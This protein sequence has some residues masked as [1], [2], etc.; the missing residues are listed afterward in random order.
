ML[1]TAA[2]ASAWKYACS[3]SMTPS[4]SAHAMSVER[5]GPMVI[6]SP[7]TS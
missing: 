7:S 1:K 4:G 3:C 6:V 5:A 2:L